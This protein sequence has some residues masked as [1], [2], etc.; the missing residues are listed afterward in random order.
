M[1]PADVI[2]AKRYANAFS[3]LNKDLDLLKK[4]FTVLQETATALDIGKDFLSNPTLHKESKLK[5]MSEVLQ[6][7][8]VNVRNFILVLI[9]NNR[10][11]LLTPILKEIENIIYKSQNIV[12]AGIAVA[13]EISLQE[14]KEIEK[15]LEKIL[16]KKLESKFS[17]DKSLLMGFKAHAE[18]I[19][20][21]ASLANSL[22]QLK[23]DLKEE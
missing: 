5:I 7:A 2:V 22:I 9:E 16:N 8:D 13:F 10:Y 17:V 6:D 20:I 19:L 12:R 4:S 18:D 21:D 1:Q 3:L 23:Q 15:Q 11:N 14:Q